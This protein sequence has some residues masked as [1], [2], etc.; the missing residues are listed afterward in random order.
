MG[1]GVE[2]GAQ[3]SVEFGMAVAVKGNPQGADA[4]EIALA[5]RI[6]KINAIAALDNERVVVV[7]LLHLGKGVPDKGAVKLFEP[8]A[9]K[10]CRRRHVR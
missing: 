10:G 4:I 1:D 9:T 3:G 8:L 2:L 6:D 5:I 7:V